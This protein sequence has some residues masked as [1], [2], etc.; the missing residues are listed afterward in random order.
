MSI[1]EAK[2]L[3]L[4][5]SALRRE[6]TV[7]EVA[8]LLGL[9]ERQ[10]KRMKKGVRE[11]GPEY[12]IHGNRGRTPSNAINHATK[13]TILVLATED[14]RETSCE[15]MSEL[16]KE[17]KD[18]TVSGKSIA[19]ILRDAGVRLRYSKKQARRRRSRERMP[20]RGMLLQCDAS[21]YRWLEDRGSMMALHGAIDDATGQ[22]L[23]LC[24]RPTED[25]HGYLVMLKQ[26]INNHG[27]P[28]ALYSDRHTIFFSPKK[29]KLSIEDELAGKVVPLTQFG[30]ALNFLGITHIAARTPQAKGRI[31]RLWETLQSRLVVEL[32]IAG[33][34]NIDEANAFLPGFIARFNER[35]AV[36]PKETQDE[37]RSP[38]HAESV[39]EYLSY[40]EKRSASGGSTIS[41]CGVTYQLVDQR[42]RV[43]PLRPRASIELLT[44]LDST[45]K[46]IYQGQTYDLRILSKPE[47]QIGS[48]QTNGKQ[49]SAP[50]KPEP[51]HPWRQ[52]KPRPPRTL[53]EQYVAN[54]AWHEN[55]LGGGDT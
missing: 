49:I 5:E 21:P 43:L 36:K 23:A 54:K 12:L 19:R 31:E 45:T 14:F 18:I 22:I 47:K 29:D 51:G 30:T 55:A 27:V 17:H 20:R 42:G 16:L 4:I 10:V 28:R 48:L 3:A 15:H 9:S 44:K 38:P 40:R 7:T 39:D 6:R 8:E 25:L 33:I 34:K 37:F 46:A 50:S 52:F 41:Y 24:F 35:F 53:I 13:E 32:R 26:V 1:A 2:R 11:Q